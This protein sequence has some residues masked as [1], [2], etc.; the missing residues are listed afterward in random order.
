MS[1]ATLLVLAAGLGQRYG[2]LKQLDPVGPAG[3]T[4]LDYSLYDACRAGFSRAVFVIRREMEAAFW[5]TVGD[6][7]EK[8]LAVQVVFQEIKAALPPSFRIPSEREKPWGT[9]HAVLVCQDVVTTPFSVIN[10][11]DFYG[12]SAY[13]AVYAWLQKGA[14]LSGDQEEY[15]FVGYSLAGTLSEFGAV[16]RAVCSLD[17]MGILKG[18]EEMVSIEKQGQVIR[19]RRGK[20]EWISMTGEEIVSLNMWGFGPSVFPL[21][22]EHFSL[23]LEQSGQD[24]TAEFFLPSAINDFIQRGQARVHYLPARENWFG[25]T[26]PSDLALARAR[27]KELIARGLYP[28]NIRP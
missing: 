17:E 3:E 8:R 24:P 18:I 5:D 12:P 20:G 4:L 11:D 19:A 1:E 2:G 9:A 28:E 13:Q 16:S 27:I 22:T 26:Y 14:K 10:A 7:W 21:L 25:V 15:C 6:Y 23:F